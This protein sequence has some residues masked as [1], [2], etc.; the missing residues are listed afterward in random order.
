MRLA[1]VTSIGASYLVILSSEDAAEE[2]QLSNTEV[3]QAV[4]SETKVSVAFPYSLD[5]LLS[6]SRAY[7]LCVM[8]M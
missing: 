6:L 7:R 1:R 5:T 8:L 4:Q 2:R 3:I